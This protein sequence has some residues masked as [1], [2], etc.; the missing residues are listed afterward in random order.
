M[1]KFLTFLIALAV[2]VGAAQFHI[3]LNAYMIALGTNVY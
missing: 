2:T 1:R 3:D